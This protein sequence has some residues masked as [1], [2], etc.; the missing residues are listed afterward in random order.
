MFGLAVQYGVSQSSL[1]N[2]D[3]QRSGITIDSSHPAELECLRNEDKL[4]GKVGVNRHCGHENLVLRYITGSECSCLLSLVQT[5]D[6]PHDS[7]WFLKNDMSTV[8]T[9]YQNILDTLQ[10]SLNLC[11]YG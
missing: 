2:A 4:L 1:D 7:Y 3:E 10:S 6:K 11:Q 8:V 9:S 5:L